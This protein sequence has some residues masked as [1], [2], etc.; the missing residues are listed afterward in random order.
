M[1]ALEPVDSPAA[2]AVVAADDVVELVEMMEEEEDAT[3][4]VVDLSDACQ[5][6]WYRGAYSVCGSRLAV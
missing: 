4:V 5:L 1:A 6:I 2:A 3:V